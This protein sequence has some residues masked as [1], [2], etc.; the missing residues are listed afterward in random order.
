MFIVLSILSTA[1]AQTPQTNLVNKASLAIGAGTFVHEHDSVPHNHYF[2]FG[3]SDG[4][5]KRDGWHY[6]PVGKFYMIAKHE[7]EVHMIAKSYQ[8]ERFMVTKVDGDLT[9]VFEG[10]ATVKHMEEDWQKGWKFTVEAFDSRSKGE[11]FIHIAFTA[12]DG[13]QHHMEGAL[14]S[15]NILIK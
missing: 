12:P 11:D 4:N 14:T 3:V 9:A 5:L 7:N 15:G 10:V 2:A 1:N 6:N 13:T 8:I